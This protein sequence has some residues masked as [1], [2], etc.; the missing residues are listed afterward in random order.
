MPV[1]TIKHLAILKKATVGLP[2]NTNPDLTS[3]TETELNA[4]LDAVSDLLIARGLNSNS[5][6]SSFGLEIEAL[7]DALNG[8]LVRRDVR[9]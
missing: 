1:L 8:E 6:P 9:M 3:W 5:E 4:A 7:I 2:G